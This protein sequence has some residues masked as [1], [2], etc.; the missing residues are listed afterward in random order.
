MIIKFSK[1]FQNQ[2]KKLPQK[3][4]AKTKQ[5]IELWREDPYNSLLR[6]HRLSGELSGYYSINITGDVRVLYA[7]IGNAVY[8]FD[9]VGTHSQLYG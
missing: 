5:R 4:Q 7:V 1:Q 8:L 9:L 2:Y 3:L 6:L